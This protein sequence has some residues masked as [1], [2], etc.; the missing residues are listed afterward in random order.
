M[1]PTIVFV[2]AP[3]LAKMQ[4]A[5]VLLVGALKTTY[6]LTSSRRS[7]DLIICVWFPLVFDYPELHGLSVG[8]CLCTYFTI[9]L[10]DQPASATLLTR[11]TMQMVK[12]NESLFYSHRGAAA[13]NN[14]SGISEVP[15]PQQKYHGLF[16]RLL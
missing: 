9:F 5:I 1:I 11:T 2:F 4:L 10:M 3:S 15:K 13:V 14:S 16:K 7:G 6:W 12:G 8:S